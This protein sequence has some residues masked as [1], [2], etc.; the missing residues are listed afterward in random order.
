MKHSREGATPQDDGTLLGDCSC[1]AVYIVPQGGDEFGALE[2]AQAA[3][4]LGAVIPPTAGI[5]ADFTPDELEALVITAAELWWNED[6]REEL[7]ERQRAL[8]E[9][10]HQWMDAR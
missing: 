2:A 6:A 1:G 3:H 4:V 5:L 10:A 8:A 9:H 7:S